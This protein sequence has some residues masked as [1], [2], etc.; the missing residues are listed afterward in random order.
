MIQAQMAD[1]TVLQFPDGTPDAVVD[2]AATE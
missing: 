2:K 1:G